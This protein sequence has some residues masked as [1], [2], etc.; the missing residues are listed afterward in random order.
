[1]KDITK[2]INNF[3]SKKTTPKKEVKEAKP[4]NKPQYHREEK[5]YKIVGVRFEL[6]EYNEVLKK[7]VKY[8]SMSDY[9]KT[10]INKD[11]NK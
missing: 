3:T 7:A 8:R 11:I 9:I 5:E 2:N 1:M 6:S 4:D 10:L